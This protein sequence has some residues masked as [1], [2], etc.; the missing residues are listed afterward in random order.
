MLCFWKVAR[1][2]VVVSRSARRGKRSFVYHLEEGGNMK[3]KKLMLLIAM[4]AMVVSRGSYAGAQVAEEPAAEEPAAE[5]PAAEEPA[6]ED[7]CADIF[8]DEQAELAEVGAYPTSVSEEAR[9]CEDSGVA[10]PYPPPYF[11]DDG[12]LLYTLD[13]IEDL[14]TSSYDPVAGVY[15][16]YDLV[17]KAFYTLPG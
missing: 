2:K 4:L 12:G 7:S 1:Q 10:N 17:T 16:V 13:P 6:A 11:Y 15:H 14:Y 9:G 3:I 8:R 5:E